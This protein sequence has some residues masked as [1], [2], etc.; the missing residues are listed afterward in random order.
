[1]SKKKK[2]KT[3]E[4]HVDLLLIEEEEGEEGKRHYVII[5]DFNTFMYDYT[6]QYERKHFCQYCLQAFSTEKIL[7]CYVQDC[8]EINGKQM[9][10]IPKKGEYVIFKNYERKI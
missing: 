8:F 7:E 5:K 4:K 2:K 1:M 9:I 3:E 6:L 10:K